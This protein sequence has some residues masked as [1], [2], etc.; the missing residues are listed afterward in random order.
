MW[1][2]AVPGE[3]PGVIVT[4]ALPWWNE[5]PEDLDAC[6]RA[7]GRVADRIIA[8]DGAYA[9]YP[10]A[11]PT[12]D[13]AQAEAIR[14]AAADVGMECEIVLPPRVWRGQIEK[15]CRLLE[16]ATQ[17]SDWIVTIDADHIIHT[18]R[19]GT[20]GELEASFHDVYAVPY[21]TPPNPERSVEESAAGLW[22]IQQVG[23]QPIIPHIW[24][25][26]PGLRVEIHHWWYSAMIGGQRVWL[27]V[28]GDVRYPTISWSYLKTPYSVEHRCL[29]RTPEQILAS[30]AFLND[31]E[32]IV[33]RTGQEDD[34]PGLD[35]PVW[36]YKRIPT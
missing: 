14:A 12:S 36:D 27:W 22:H 34:V 35:P 4:A 5:R 29:M 31:R 16:L 15:R 18:E 20:R 21:W 2:S 3:D 6:V 32:M 33:R 25:A 11:T 19:E 10:G 8:L 13:P 30:R 24:R 28:S 7:A 17:Q 1:P 9:R 23:T 26:H